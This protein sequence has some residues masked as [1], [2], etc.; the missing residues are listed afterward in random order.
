M[1]HKTIVETQF[2]QEAINLENMEKA[3][4]RPG[5]QDEVNIR[6]YSLKQNMTMLKENLP[7]KK[8][9]FLGLDSLEGKMTVEMTAHEVCFPH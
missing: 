7:G 4:Y 5:E 8:T 6:E 9:V 3:Y 2:V 1:S